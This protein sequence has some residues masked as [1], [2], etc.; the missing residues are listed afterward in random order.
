[1]PSLYGDEETEEEWK[2]EEEK[3]TGKI[4][5]ETK[6]ERQRETYVGDIELFSVVYT[7]NTSLS[8]GDEMVIVYIVG[9]E[10]QFWLKKQTPFV[11]RW[12]FLFVCLTSEIDIKD[13]IRH[14]LLYIVFTV[15][16]Y[17]YSA[18]VHDTGIVLK[19]N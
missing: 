4:R 14:G 2:E 13:I 9:Q 18:H 6:R 3:Q 12:V 7:G 1:M 5:R 11:M 15:C 10:T 17:Y 19:I 8:L 16:V